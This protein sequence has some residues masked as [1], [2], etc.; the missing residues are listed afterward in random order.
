MR[1]GHRFNYFTYLTFSFASSKYIYFI[2]DVEETPVFLWYYHFRWRRHVDAYIEQNPT[3]ALE[4]KTMMPPQWIRI[5]LIIVLYAWTCDTIKC[6][7]IRYVFNAIVPNNHVIMIHEIKYCTPG[8]KSCLKLES[9][10]TSYNSKHRIGLQY[11]CKIFVWCHLFVTL[12][13]LLWFEVSIQ[14]LVAGSM[15]TF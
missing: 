15:S 4:L 1:S 13:V 3:T 14:S 6:L 7:L 10:A 2:T 9:Y 11:F 12:S 5:V 8:N